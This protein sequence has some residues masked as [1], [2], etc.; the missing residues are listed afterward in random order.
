M[1]EK[2]LRE[3]LKKAVDDGVTAR[4]RYYASIDLPDDQLLGMPAQEELI[5]SV[6]AKIGRKLPPSYR[7]FLSLHNGWHMVDGVTDLLSVEEM[8]DGPTAAKVRKWQSDCSKAGDTVAATGLVIGWAD[9][10]P[11]RLILDSSEVDQDGE[12][13]LLQHYKDEECDYPSFLEWLEESV[14]D[15]EALAEG[16]DEVDEE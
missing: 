16:K 6:E 10:N 3:R 13:R 4:S 9:I 14:S 8:L 5:A 15:F 7:S 1:D 11:T 2:Q 12:W